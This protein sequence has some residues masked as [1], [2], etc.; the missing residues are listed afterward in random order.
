MTEV[1]VVVMWI[2]LTLLLVWSV[3]GMVCAHKAY[4]QL[5]SLIP[6]VGDL[7]FWEKIRA[8]E[9]VPFE[10]HYRALMMFKDPYTL[11]D[12]IIFKQ[13]TVDQERYHDYISRMNREIDNAT[14]K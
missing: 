12:P 2:V 7:D 11:Y 4:K 1:A 14:D 10:K 8:L 6:K 9:A 5:S 3:W 13:S